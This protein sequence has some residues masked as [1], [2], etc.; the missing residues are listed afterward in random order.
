M[1]TLRSWSIKNDVVVGRHG[2]ARHVRADAPNQA[3]LF[4]LDD[5]RVSSVAA[6]TVW[7]IRREP[8]TESERNTRANIRNACVGQTVFQLEN[9][10]VDYKYDFGR[11]CIEEFLMELQA[12]QRDSE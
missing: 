2:H 9:M 1:K 12:E 4:G 3:G 5:Y 8:F 10:L 7:L 6:G 11:D